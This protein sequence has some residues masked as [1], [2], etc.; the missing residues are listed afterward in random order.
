MKIG[1]LGA[2]VIVTAAVAG[3][4][5][6]RPPQNEPRP[7]GQT[8]DKAIVPALAAEDDEALTFPVET[9][10]TSNPAGRR[11]RLQLGGGEATL[12]LIDP[13]SKDE[14]MAF[15]RGTLQAT[16]RAHGAPLIAAVARWLHQAPPGPP[17]APGELQ[18]LPL[19]YVRLGDDGTWES[20]KLFLQSGSLEAEVFINVRL[21]GKQA[22]LVEKDDDYRRPLL[23]LLAIAVRDG[24]PSRRKSG[25]D[26]AGAAPLVPSLAPIVGSDHVGQPQVWMGGVWIAALE[27]DDKQKVLYWNDLTKDPRRLAEVTG[28]V[29][30]LAP[31]PKRD[32]VALLVLHPK[33]PKTVSSE[34]PGEVLVAA[35]DGSAPRSVV[36]GGPDFS[37]TMF[38]RVSWSP[39]GTTLTIPGL[40]PGKVPRVS[41]TR[42]YDVASGKML[43]SATT[44]KDRKAPA[45]SLR[46]PD[47]RYTLAVHETSVDISGPGGRRRFQ[48]RSEGDRSAVEALSDGPE[49]AAWLGGGALVL[50][51]ETPMALDLAA[52][53]LRYIFPD[54]E[55]QFMSASDDGTIVVARDDAKRLLWGRVAPAR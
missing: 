48:P 46:S 6:R 32:R 41:L 44:P 30:A 23:T 51:S 55:L 16:D 36:S 39:D 42:V 21:D 25:P 10:R 2:L 54:D 27:G 13:S 17:D 12:T 7:P 22:R 15:G 8:T 1:K 35:M 47:G 37:P 50:M 34:D 52:A 49:E 43:S 3:C 14:G 9:T 38:S 28:S 53:K 20:N 26:L 24:K 18:P 19:N 40:V 29:I 31:S 45:A 33:Q 11:I 5:S 4:K